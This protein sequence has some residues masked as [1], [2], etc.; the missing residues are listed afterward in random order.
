MSDLNGIRQYFAEEIRAVANIR[1]EALINAFAAVPREQFLG[2][3]PWQ[4]MSAS[5][6]PG[7]GGYRTTEDADP[8]HV[9]HNVLIAIDP[10]RQLNNG[11][12]SSIAAWLDALDL[13]QGERIVHVGCGVGYYTAIMAEVVG[14]TGQVIGIEIDAELAARARQNLSY[15]R[16]VEVVHGDGG[17]HNPGP[18]DVI[19]VNAGV[20]H[21]Q[22][23]WL[24]SLRPGGR[25]MVPITFS[26]Q[27]A[28]V[29]TG[30]MLKVKRES[31]GFATR[32]VSPVT[33]YHCVAVRDVDLNQRLRNS[34][35]RGAW[36]SVQSLRRESHKPSESC[37]FHDDRFCLSQLP[38]PT[39]S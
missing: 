9:Y 24:N 1:S 16:H 10:D 30:F 33:I 35:M 38:V 34:F 11:Q 39:E 13:R 14:P 6:E 25:L 37:W 26:T 8:R 3:G 32:F 31:K 12:P 21:P 15:L 17:E 7:G 28:G 4:I 5:T 22:P 19:F 18:S 36:Q 29:G 23:A 27:A 20:T 2:P